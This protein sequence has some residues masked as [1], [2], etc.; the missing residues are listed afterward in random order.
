[1]E[2]NLVVGAG[3]HFDIP[4]LEHGISVL[5][6][7]GK[8]LTLDADCLESDIAPHIESS[9]LALILTNFIRRQIC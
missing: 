3:C 2:G 4:V 9:F 5:P 7:L 8:P 1:M 6:H